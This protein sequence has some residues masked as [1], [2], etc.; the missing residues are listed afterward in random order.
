MTK[1]ELLDT[2][3]DKHSDLM[4]EPL[5]REVIEKV[6]ATITDHMDSE[7]FDGQDRWATLMALLGLH[8]EVTFYRNPNGRRDGHGNRVPYNSIAIGKRH[9]ATGVFV[10]G[11]K[12]FNQGFDDA[13]EKARQ[14]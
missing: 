6:L 11:F 10:D 14:R 12:H 9:T 2:V 1:D 5:F 3:W 4:S 7:E 8:G 13:V